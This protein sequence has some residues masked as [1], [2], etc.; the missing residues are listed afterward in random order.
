V[1][2]VAKRILSDALRLPRKTR[3]MLAEKLLESLENP[4]DL[5]AAIE[6]GE[7]RWQAYKDGKLKG[8]PIEDLF[9]NLAS[10]INAKKAK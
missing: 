5:D 10:K 4:E 6:E 2:Q 3:A 1:S 9:P 7:E 8:V